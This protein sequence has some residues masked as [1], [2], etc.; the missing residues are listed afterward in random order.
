MSTTRIPLSFESFPDLTWGQRRKIWSANFKLVGIALFVSLAALVG[1]ILSVRFFPPNIDFLEGERIISAVLGGSVGLG[2]TLWWESA[3]TWASIVS[4]NVVYSK[5]LNYKLNTAQQT[6]RFTQSDAVELLRWHHSLERTLDSVLGL[7]RGL[8]YD[9]L[10]DTIAF[11]T[12]YKELNEHT[13][14]FDLF[15]SQKSGFYLLAE[16]LEAKPKGFFRRKDK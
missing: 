15:W 5:E 3:Q 7:I 2:A 1:Y 16:D 10:P 14:K 6:Y 9:N 8:D 12:T 11:G 4:N 13:I